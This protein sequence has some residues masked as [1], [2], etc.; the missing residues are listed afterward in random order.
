MIKYLNYDY[1]NKTISNDTYEIILHRLIKVKQK[2]RKRTFLI[3]K[4]IDIS[5]QVHKKN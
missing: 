5:D 3:V 4:I 1:A 2:H